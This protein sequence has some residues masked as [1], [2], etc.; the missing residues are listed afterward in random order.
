MLGYQQKTQD[1]LPKYHTNGFKPCCYC[2]ACCP[3]KP[4]EDGFCYSH[5]FQ[6]Y[7]LPP[8]Y[9]TYLSH[10]SSSA[11][12]I[13]PAQSCCTLKVQT[14]KVY[15]LLTNEL[16]RFFGATTTLLVPTLAS[17][18]LSDQKQCTGER[19]YFCLLITERGV[20]NGVEGIK[21]HHTGS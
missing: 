5:Y 8:F 17:D 10:L 16:F 3:L 12:I 11:Y 13:Q 6:H 14:F 7:S 1:S 21:Y 15:T 19:I 9:Q 18:T 20:Y 4:L 2:S